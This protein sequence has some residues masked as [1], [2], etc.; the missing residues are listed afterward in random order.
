MS[1]IMDHLQINPWTVL[2]NTD[3]GGF[4]TPLG[5]VEAILVGD[6]GLRA[7]ICT[8]LAAGEM[9][10]QPTTGR[11]ELVRSTRIDLGAS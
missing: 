5:A 11:S 7:L 4:E 9:I 10:S 6:F 8:L 3:A 1:Q 2:L